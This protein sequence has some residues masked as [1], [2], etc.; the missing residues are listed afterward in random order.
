[1]STTLTSGGLGAAQGQRW[2]FKFTTASN[3]GDTNTVVLTV[4]AVT[5]G[6]LLVAYKSQK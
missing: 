6:A 2:K 5:G 4:P 3:A 1:M